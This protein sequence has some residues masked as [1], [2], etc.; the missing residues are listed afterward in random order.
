MTCQAEAELRACAHLAYICQL[1]YPKS[2]M[3][4]LRIFQLFLTFLQLSLPVPV[5]GFEPTAL[6]LWMFYHC[7]TCDMTK[8]LQLFVWFC[9]LFLPFISA[10]TQE[11]FVK[12]LIVWPLVNDAAPPK[13]SENLCLKDKRLR[14]LIFHVEKLEKLGLVYIFN[15]S[16]LRT[17]LLFDIS[18]SDSGRIQTLNLLIMSG[19]LYHCTTVPLRAQNHIKDIRCCLLLSPFISARMQKEVWERVDGLS[20]SQWCCTTQ[21]IGK[22][23]SERLMLEGTANHK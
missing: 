13:I 1:A 19:V 17:Y 5:E 21:N 22:P 20:I 8:L 23:S 6:G 11:R 16:S 7:G 15:Q 12:G 10:W 4:C 3:W 18:L 9:F 14:A 2:I